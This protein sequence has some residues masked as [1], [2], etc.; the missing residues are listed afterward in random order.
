MMLWPGNDNQQQGYINWASIDGVTN[1][2][3]GGSLI[4]VVAG[5]NPLLLAIIYINLST[6]I[7]GAGKNTGIFN[8]IIRMYLKS[9]I[10]NI[11]TLFDPGRC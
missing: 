5:E 3:A 10:G 7:Y 6:V 2:Y 9:F 11:H 8:G 1:G 4:Y